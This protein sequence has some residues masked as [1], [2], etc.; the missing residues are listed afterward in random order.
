MIAPWA[1]GKICAE[2][3]L[4]EVTLARE[5]IKNASPA[6]SASPFH[7]VQEL[8][9]FTLEGPDATIGHIEDFLVDDLN[10]TICFLV[11]EMCYPSVGKNVLIPPQAI[12]NAQWPDSTFYVH[13]S[14]KELASSSCYPAGL[15]S[16]FDT[17][18]A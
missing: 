10:W 17:V 9:G 6:D 18:A 16:V 8:T 13:I 2:L 7:S 14:H 4:L 5:T 12:T 15:I 11:T 1:L 3:K